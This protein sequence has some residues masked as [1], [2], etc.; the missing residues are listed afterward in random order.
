[1][2]W[3][4]I[5]RCF[6]IKMPSYHYRESHCGYEMVVRYIVLFS[7]QWNVIYLYDSFC[8]LKYTP[9]GY[10]HSGRRVLVKASSTSCSVTRQLFLCFWVNCS[11]LHSPGVLAG[12]SNARMSWRMTEV[13][14]G[15]LAAVLIWWTSTLPQSL[16]TLCMRHLRWNLPL[17][18]QG[19]FSGLVQDCGNSNALAWYHLCHFIFT[20]E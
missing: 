17:V 1:M 15:R 11:Y 7:P 3:L 10:T 9:I 16:I 6:N 2:W 4:A 12:I 5:S 20:S 19:H 14:D 18:S 13:L 8:I